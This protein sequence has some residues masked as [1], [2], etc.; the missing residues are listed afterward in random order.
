[1]PEDPVRARA[2]LVGGNDLHDS[3]PDRAMDGLGDAD[4]P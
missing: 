3:I 2:G 4:L 1:L